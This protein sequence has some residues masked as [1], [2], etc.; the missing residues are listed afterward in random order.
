MLDSLSTPAY[1][2]FKQQ[3][4]EREK[5]S[6]QNVLSLEGR[7]KN[8]NLQALYTSFEDLESIFQSQYIKGTWLDLGGGSGRTCLLYSFLTGRPSINV[9]IDSARSHITDLI[10]SQYELPVENFCDDLLKC[11]LPV[12]D[13]YFLYFPTG[14]I[15]DRVLDVL[16]V[17]LGFSL[18]VI[19]SHGDLIARIEKEK[20]YVLVEKINLKSPRHYPYAHIYQK[21]E[22]VFDFNPHKLSFR[23]EILI[24]RDALGEWVADSFGLQW[25]GGDSY[26]FLNPP[27][28]ILWTEDFAGILA[29]DD[30]HYSQILQL[31]KWRRQGEL[32]FMLKNGEEKKGYIRKIRVSPTFALEISSGELIECES[33]KNILKGI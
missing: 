14:H 2:N 31:S 5:Q 22:T 18:V 30:V 19:E 25:E 8:L 6:E 23:D 24:I 9:E 4:E 15:L 20:G 16:S 17:R 33:L 1:L 28:S 29:K 3:L 26:Q 12:A 7:Y 21:N 27:R 13:V 11:S 32:R 10:S